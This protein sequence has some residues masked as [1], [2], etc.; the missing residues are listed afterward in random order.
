MSDPRA[1]SPYRIPQRCPADRRNA[2]NATIA[3]RRELYGLRTD[4]LA[5]DPA[6]G[7]RLPP[8]LPTLPKEEQFTLQKLTD[9]LRHKVQG[10]LNG[11]FGSGRARTVADYDR[12]YR[13]VPPPDHIAEWNSDEEFARQRVAGVNP[14]HL[15]AR[16]TDVSGPLA[17]V[18]KASLEKHGT[19]IAKVLDAGR[20]FETDYSSLADER[21]QK[22]VIASKRWLAAPRCVFFVDDGGVLRPI[23]ISFPKDRSCDE[24]RAY[25][26][27]SDRWA[28]TI[29]KWHTQTAD[30]ALHEGFYHL[31]ETHM[32]TELIA[33]CAARH[34]HVDH[35]IA[36]LLAPHTQFNLAIDC[37]ARSDMLAPG[38]AIDL[39]LSSGSAGALNAVR[40]QIASG[41]SWSARRIDRDLAARG[42]ADPKRLPHYP[43]R[44]YGATLHDILAS[45]VREVM[46]P[47]YRSDGDVAGD[48]ELAGW[49]AEVASHMNG[50]PARTATLEELFDTLTEIVFR[51]S[52]QH[53]AVNNGQYD[54]YGHV[55]TAPGALF[56]APPS[57]KTYTEKDALA[58]LPRGAGAIAQIGMAWTLSEPTHYGLFGIGDAPAFDAVYEP[59]ARDAVASV[60]RRLVAFSRDLEEREAASTV[61]Y[62]YL[63]PRNIERSTGT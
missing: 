33:I 57:A 61:P 17:D 43:Y 4:D 58:A 45:Y 9:L 16:D 53:A 28:W 35:P 31:Y 54:S 62:T 15:R 8:Y 52:A 34:L 63:D 42:V 55:P 27:E 41:W 19:T 1:P 21:V 37:L 2:R 13:T 36:H 12:M 51:A 5:G 6:E 48:D 26:P 7:F 32:V 56:T 18:V 44:E 23:G 40:M 20:L 25:G 29:A 49:L 11:W 22:Y 39:A 14:M 47:F 38:K 60:R 50:F 59:Q 10:Q 30:G 3:A 46:A 24:E